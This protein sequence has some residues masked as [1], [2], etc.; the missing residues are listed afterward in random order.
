M[1][2]FIE[3]MSERSTWRGAI[4]M[5]SALGVTLEPQLAEAVI[6]LGLGLAGLAEALLPDPA[7]K[8]KGE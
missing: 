7:G 4:M 6:A 2:F 1:H 5:L 8:M 3:R